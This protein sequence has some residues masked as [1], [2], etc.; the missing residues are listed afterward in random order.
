[1]HFSKCCLH[2]RDCVTLDRFVCFALCGATLDA[3]TTLYFL[4]CRVG[5]EANPVLAPLVERSLLWVPVYCYSLALL[6]AFMTGIVRQAFAMFY[7][8][9]TLLAGL[10]NL[11]GILTGVWL[12]ALFRFDFPYVAGLL[13]GVLTFSI[14]CITEYP[15][16][17]GRYTCVLVNAMLWAA[18]FAFVEFAFYMVRYVA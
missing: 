17:S 3:T 5:Y 10:S 15:R 13:A 14:F 8:L 6:T 2:L 18:T 11:S 9:M 7:G 16:I 4:S 1:M 12:V